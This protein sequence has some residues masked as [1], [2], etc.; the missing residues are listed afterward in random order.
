[1]T[2]KI[3]LGVGSGASSLRTRGLSR[4]GNFWYHF[5]V[6]NHIFSWD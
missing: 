3:N 1:M 4:K 6:S 5:S 2:E